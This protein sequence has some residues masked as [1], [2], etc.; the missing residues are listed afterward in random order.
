MQV[1]YGV[2]FAVAVLAVAHV[3]IIDTFHREAVDGFRRLLIVVEIIFVGV[4]LAATAAYF[5]ALSRER[6]GRRVLET[7]TEAFASPLESGEAPRTAVASL[8]G[9][10]VASAA[11]LALARD[12]GHRLDP[13]AASGY[14]FGATLEERDS[15]GLV[16]PQPVVRQQVELTD[17]WLDLVRGQIGREPWIARVP[18]LRGDELLGLLILADPEPGL[19]SDPAFLGP[20]GALLTVALSADGAA[21]P[22]RP[23]GVS[24]EEWARHELIEATA[25]E[26]GPALIAVEAF[27]SSVAGDA[28]DV[29]TIEDARRLSTLALSVERLG[30]IMSDLSTLGAGADALVVGDQE[31]IDLT[32]ILDASVDALEPAFRAR[33]QALTLELTNEPLTAFLSPD[34]VERLLLHLLSNANRAAPDGGAVTVRATNLGEAIRIEVEDSSTP[35]PG[36][37]LARALEP[38]HRVPERAGVLPGAGLGLAI[39]RRLA[40]SQLG[41]LEARAT[42]SGVAYIADLPVDPPPPP[43]EP[44]VVPEPEDDDIEDEDDLL[45]VDDEPAYDGDEPEDRPSDAAED[46]REAST[47]DDDIVEDDLEL[48][49]ADDLNAD[50]VQVID[51]DLDDLDDATEADGPHDDR[52]EVDSDAS[53]RR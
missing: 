47:A 6:S 24:A 8:V 51:D 10:G 1:L 22:S 18:I 37:Q 21:S 31:S 2:A 12:Q 52:R 29:G 48:E 33:E 53:P 50:L 32:P 27:A 45:D 35:L 34:A 4:L 16:P 7:L 17:P 40:E 26:F 11:L 36:D 25:A 19:I 3:V 41:T 43:A 49:D 14:P 28:D 20:L 23:R 30:V 46:G 39:A 9:S 38:F 44:A 13:T 42:E 15:Y 5:L